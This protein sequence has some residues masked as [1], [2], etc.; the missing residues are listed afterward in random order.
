MSYPYISPFLHYQ[1]SCLKQTIGSYKWRKLLKTNKQ[2]FQKYSGKRCFILGTAPSIM[3]FD[4]KKIKDECIIAINEIFYHPDFDL[5]FNQHPD[6]K[7]ILIPPS[8]TSINEDIVV[9]TLKEMEQKISPKVTHLF[10]IDN[11]KPGYHQLITNNDFFKH[12][13]HLYF[14]AGIQT[15]LGWYRFSTKHWNLTR[16]IWSSGVG[17]IYALIVALYMNFNEIY[18]LGIDHSYLSYN[19]PASYRFYGE[20]SDSNKKTSEEIIRNQ[21][22]HQKSQNTIILEGTHL[23]FEQYTL[24]AKSTRSKIYNLSPTS[25]LDIFPRKNFHDI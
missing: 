11:F 21:E 15:Q 6:N 25:I 22:V 14:R 7:F 10:G 16:N 1:L 24:I 12:H 23:A 2:L 8:H 17:S 4:L 13:N 5:I 3:D 19:D 9:Q 20:H 18:L